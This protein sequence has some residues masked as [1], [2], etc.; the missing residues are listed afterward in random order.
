MTL[1]IRRKQTLLAALLISL[2]L[3]RAPLLMANDAPVDSDGDGIP[4]EQDNLPTLATLPLHWSVQGVEIAWDGVAPGSS[5]AWNQTNAL[6]LFNRRERGD[7]P[8]SRLGASATASPMDRIGNEAE[9]VNG[10]PLLGTFGSDEPPWQ[11]LQRRRAR[12]F[13]ANPLNGRRGVRVLFAIHF[14]N[15]SATDWHLR[16]L[17]VPIMAG[18]RQVTMAYPDSPALA[19]RGI[20]FPGGNPWRVYGVNF[21]ATVPAEQTSAFLAALQHEAPRFAFEA[22]DGWIATDRLPDDVPLARWFENIRRQTVPVKIR[23]G[24]GQ[25]L[26]WRVARSADGQRQRLASWIAT[27]NQLAQE[28]YGRPLLLEQEGILLSLSGWDTGAWDRWWHITGSRSAGD[29]RNLVLSHEII[30]EL[31]DKPPTLTRTMRK[32]A[33]V[34]DPHPILLGQQGEL[35]RQKGDAAGALDYDQQAADMGYAPALFRLGTALAEGRGAEVNHAQAVRACQQAAN[36]SYAPA[37]A[38]LGG[39]LLR[40]DYGTKRNPVAGFGWLGKAAAQGHPDGM[41]LHALCLTRGVGVKADVTQGLAATRRSAAMGNST[42]Q[43]AL[44]IQ[45]LATNDAEALEWLTCAAEAGN[46]KA[47]ARLA[48]CLETGE[49]GVRNPKAAAVWNARAAAQG[50]AAA[51]LALGRA[52]RSGNGVKRNPRQAAHWFSQAAEQG[53]PEAQTWWGLAL[54]NG[55]GVKRDTALGI[56]WIRRAAEQKHPQAQYLMGL[57][58]YAGLSGT[59]ADPSAALKWFKAAAAQQILPARIFVGFCYYDGRGVAQNHKEAARHFREA[60]EQG[61]PIGQIWLSHCHANGE[62]VERDLNL[63]R[64]WA[65]KAWQQGHPG[66]RQMLRRIPAE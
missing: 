63:A 44:A 9:A 24:D 39:V 16:G 64:E 56:D 23:G 45:L 33:A 55:Q 65:Q 36:Q 60:A 66:G 48:R 8:G 29:W 59:D 30:F 20:I 3:G 17:R 37:A 26:V 5:S 52:L 49:G 58:T 50:E 19:V 22:A 15:F 38:W 51:Q 25:V 53:N 28:N 57:C 13:A 31:S 27:V 62:G 32:R 1:G 21:I 2:L 12:R 7:Q 40:G 18:G 54:L 42:A 4:D 6:T 43:L 10:L 11:A 46:A 61:S 41:G 35:A 34:A 14:R 47:Q